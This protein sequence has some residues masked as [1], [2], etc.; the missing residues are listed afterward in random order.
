MI[1]LLHIWWSQ[2]FSFLQQFHPLHIVKDD[3]DNND[4]NDDDN[5]DNDDNNDTND[6]NDYKQRQ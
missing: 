4:N 3:N 5:D 2:T 6:N 1:W